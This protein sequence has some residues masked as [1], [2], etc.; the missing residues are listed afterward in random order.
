MKSLELHEIE[1]ATLC[2]AMTFDRLREQIGCP[3][4]GALCTLAGIIEA[5]AAGVTL[6]QFIEEVRR[7]WLVNFPDKDQN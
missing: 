6:E 1:P 5:H 3:R 2:E 4:F 7:D